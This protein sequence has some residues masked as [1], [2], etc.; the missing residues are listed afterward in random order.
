MFD[1][2]SEAVKVERVPEAS[3]APEAVLPVARAVTA[4]ASTTTPPAARLSTVAVTSPSLVRARRV[5]GFAAAPALDCTLATTR[6]APLVA[7]APVVPV[8]VFEALLVSVVVDAT[9]VKSMPSAS[10]MRLPDDP[11]T[12]ASLPV[13]LAEILLPETE[14]MPVRVLSWP[15]DAFV[16]LT[17]SETSVPAFSAAMSVV[18]SGLALTFDCRLLTTADAVSVLSPPLSMVIALAVVLPL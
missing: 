12:S 4:L 11:V 18:A 1:K 2:A 15:P 7:C 6:L 3:I 16:L 9:P 13:A 8:T 17:V 10:V 14:A 5:A